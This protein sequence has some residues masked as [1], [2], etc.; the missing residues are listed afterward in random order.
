MKR[1]LTPVINP[2]TT[3]KRNEPRKGKVTI[4]AGRLKLREQIWVPLREDLRDYLRMMP[5]GEQN[6]MARALDIS[7]SQIHRYVCPDCEHDQEPVFTIGV[8]IALY[9]GYNIAAL[10]AV[11]RKYGM[12]RV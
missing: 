12:E 1:R 6:R 10:N 2:L 9:L 3:T 8:A 5:K 4:R 7:P 11:R